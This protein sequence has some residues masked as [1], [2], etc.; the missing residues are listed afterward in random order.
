[1]IPPH[2]PK[3]QRSCSPPRFSSQTVGIPEPRPM[4]TQDTGLSSDKALMWV[5]PAVQAYLR[6]GGVAQVRGGD[7]RMYKVCLPVTRR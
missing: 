7:G 4:R 6:N 3:V 2:R 1:M 5:T